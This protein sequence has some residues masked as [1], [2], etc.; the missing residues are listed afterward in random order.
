MSRIRAAFLALV[1]PIAILTSGCGENGLTGIEDLPDDLLVTWHGTSL[2]VNG[3]DVYDAGTRLE[4]TFHANGSFELVGTRDLGENFCGEGSDCSDI[5]AYALTTDGVIFDPDADDAVTLFYTLTPTTLRL[6]GTADGIALDLTLVRPPV[7]ELIGTWV[8]THLSGPD[9]EEISEGG[10]TTTLAFTFEANGSYSYAST[11]SPPDMFCD[12][13]V[14]CV[15]Q[16]SYVADGDLDALE[17]DPG[18]PDGL[19]MQLSVMGDQLT[20]SGDF[21]GGI[22]DW[23]FSRL[24]VDSPGE[25]GTWWAIAI[26]YNGVDLTDDGTVQELMLSGGTTYSV[27]TMDS[28]DRLLCSDED[29][30]PDCSAAGTYTASYASLEFIDG[31]EDSPLE[32]SMDVTPTTLRLFGS[33]GSGSAD[34]LY[35]RVPD[36]M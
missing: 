7:P 36:R 34:I 31:A 16:G 29:E 18:D 5:G 12:P 22:N 10:A 24:E 19:T 11:F 13:D 26:M 35:V 9:G 28:Q 27:Y 1:A 8:S 32:L 17:F 33:V 30:L 23:T 2:L 21:D 25:A 6:T 3:T 14:S 20:L 4:L 15:G